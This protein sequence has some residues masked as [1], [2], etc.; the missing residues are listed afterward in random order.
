MK[1]LIDQIKAL[2]DETR[3]RILNLLRSHELCVCDIFA[4]LDL[5]QST[6]SRHLAILRRAGWV[7]DE[8]RGSWMYYRLTDDPVVLD[9]LIPLLKRMLA[10]GRAGA[11]LAALKRISEQGEAVFCR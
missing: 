10:T 8:R 2:G 1:A 6:V 9:L 5:P 7:I 11:D 3:L 4:T